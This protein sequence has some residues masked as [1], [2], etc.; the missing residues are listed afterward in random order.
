VAYFILF[1]QKMAKSFYCVFF[2]FLKRIVKLWNF[3]T[4]KKKKK[5]KRV[6]LHAMDKGLKLLL[7]QIPLIRC[8]GD[9]TNK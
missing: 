7:Y 6:F 4:K 5:E 1:F 9:C 3:T 2:H 8:R